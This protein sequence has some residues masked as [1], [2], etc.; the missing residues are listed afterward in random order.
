MDGYIAKSIDRDRVFEQ[1]NLVIA[2][3]RR[4]KARGAA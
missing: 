3:P 2:E 1:I 4:T